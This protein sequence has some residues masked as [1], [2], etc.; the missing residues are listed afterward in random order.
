MDWA[1]SEIEVLRQNWEQGIPISKIG[2]ELNRSNNSIASKAV[3]LS[4]K[5]RLT[6]RKSAE[7]KITL[8]TA[9]DIELGYFAGLL[10]GE[11][12][13]MLAKYNRGEGVV[14]LYPVIAIANNSLELLNRAKEIAGGYI[15]HKKNSKGY[16]LRLDSNIPKA[17]KML[18][19]LIPF[20]TAK[21][22]QA[23]L[24]KEYCERRIFRRGRYTK[25]DFDYCDR[26]SKLNRS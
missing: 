25:E 9:T 20:L 16:M 12:S 15:S 18:E 6:W 2:K 14:C 26:I 8:G 17:L 23:L 3:R 7:N 21:K 13:I 4:L 22:P 24:L 11:G 19:I 5:R 1:K 10:D